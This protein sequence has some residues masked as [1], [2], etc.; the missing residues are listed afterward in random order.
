MCQL[1]VEETIEHLFCYCPSG[2]RCWAKLNISWGTQ[3][4]R[5][6]L[7]AASKQNYRKPMFMETFMLGAWSIWK[8]RNNL[9]FNAITP[10]IETWKTRFTSDFFLMVH[11][12]KEDLHPF[13]VNLVGQL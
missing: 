7:V 2:A 11:R 8:E 4:N 13:I 3:N 1:Q 9:I 5:L 6:D 10:R 12:T